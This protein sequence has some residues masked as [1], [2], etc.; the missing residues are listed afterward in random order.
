[1]LIVATLKPL[2]LSRGHSCS[3]SKKH[4]NEE[5][6][7]WICD[8]NGVAKSMKRKH[9]CGSGAIQG[10]LVF[11]KQSSIFLTYAPNSSS[12]F[13]NLFLE[14]NVLHSIA[15]NVPCQNGL[16]PAA[17]PPSNRT[18]LLLQVPTTQLNQRPPS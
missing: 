7:L 4:I 12:I 5:D 11:F 13:L 10:F 2:G 17:A 1:M 6:S 9:C 8:V 15:S 3:C 18:L 14:C 16:Q